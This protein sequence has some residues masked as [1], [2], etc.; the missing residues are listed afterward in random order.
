MIIERRKN[1]LEVRNFYYKKNIFLI[2][3]LFFKTRDD[4]IQNILEHEDNKS[5]DKILKDYENQHSDS[6]LFKWNSELK[7]TLNNSEILSQS[8]LFLLAGYETTAQT[9]C[10][11]AYNLAMN[12]FYQQ[13]LCQE[14]DSVL[15]RHVNTSYL[16]K[17]F[18]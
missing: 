15:E 10:Y 11:I 3:D 13:K 9:L 7:K 18:F 5:L 6:K 12:P 16:F 17:L 4:F 2:I 1:K 8:I 14:I